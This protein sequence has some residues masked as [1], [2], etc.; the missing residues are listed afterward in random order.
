M[1]LGPLDQFLGVALPPEK[2]WPTWL[3]SPTVRCFER[4]S[5]DEADFG[6]GLARE[7]KLP[8]SADEVVERF[9]RFPRGLFPGAAELVSSVVDPVSTGVL[10][11]T[12]KLHW[13]HQIDGEIIRGLFD[14]R[15]LSYQLGLVKPDTAIFE[16]V[17]SELDVAPADILFID[18]NQL[19]VDGARA[20]GLDAHLAR[21]VTEARLLLL[22]RELIVA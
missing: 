7:F 21:G 13:E 6:F 12:N 15:F 22:E 20:V 19:N 3:S 2:F 9:R 4:G 17:V 1:E 10:S 11:N 18:D 14:H 8:L 16:R 5:C